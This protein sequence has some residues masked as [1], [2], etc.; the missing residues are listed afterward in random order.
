MK[1]KYDFLFT[2]KILFYFFN[3]SKIIME[4]GMLTALNGE[5]GKEIIPVAN[6]AIIFIGY[7]CSI[8]Q[9]AMLYC[10]EHNCFLCISRG[11]F[12]I[13]TIYA[14]GRYRDPKSFVNQ[15]KLIENHKFEFAKE[16]L[17]LRLMIDKNTKEFNH[18]V[19]ETISLEQLLGK[20]A[21][22]AKKTYALFCEKYKIDNFKR[23]FEYKHKKKN[24]DFSPNEEINR[25]LNILNNVLYSF[26]SLLCYISS[27]EP[28]LAFIHGKT[29]RGGMAFDLADIIK[30]KVILPLC[31]D[32]TIKEENLM[33]ILRKELMENNNKLTKLLLE[34]C[35]SISQNKMINSEE[36]YDCYCA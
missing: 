9:E 17:K 33:I 29:R 34:I 26:C 19:D 20:E 2:D 36:L 11:G 23:N 27:L 25:R 1:I 6:V 22:Y 13:H 4:D 32:L 24:E 15:I 21:N 31:F 10:S 14:E 35:K 3:K 5:F 8:T 12:N 30:T 7:G 28:S 16:L 18:Y